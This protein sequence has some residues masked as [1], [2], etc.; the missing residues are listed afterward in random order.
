MSEEYEELIRTV[1]ALRS[2]KVDG[3]YW[4]LMQACV[5]SLLKIAES[6]RGKDN[7]IDNNTES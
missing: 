2:V 3:E 6:L 5:N 1:Q 7:A 4:M